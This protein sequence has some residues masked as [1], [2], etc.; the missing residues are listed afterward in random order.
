VTLKDIRRRMSDKHE[1]YIAEL[2]GSRIN[3]GSGN[4]A[5][6]PM[7]GRTDRRELPFAFAWDCKATLSDSLPVSRKM[8]HKAKEQSYGERPALPLRWYDGERL[9][10][11]EDVIVISLDDFLEM[12][13]V[14]NDKQIPHN[15]QGSIE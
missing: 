2:M 7:D 1:A 14:C 8:W 12:L 3:P 11:W 4:Q 15:A 9:A 10:H 5:N 6:K 13:E